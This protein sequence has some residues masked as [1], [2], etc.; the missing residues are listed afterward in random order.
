M[1]MQHLRA[2]RI[3]I[4]TQKRFPAHFYELFLTRISIGP[5]TLMVIH[6]H[7]DLLVGVPVSAHQVLTFLKND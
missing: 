2:K 6:R 5:I 1:Q 3:S 7:H 4:E